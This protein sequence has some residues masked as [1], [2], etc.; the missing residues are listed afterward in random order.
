MKYVSVLFVACLAATVSGII[1]T[2]RAEGHIPKTEVDLEFLVTFEDK[3][4]AK[5]LDGAQKQAEKLVKALK[6]FAGE[7]GV[8]GSEADIEAVVGADGKVT[9]YKASIEVELDLKDQKDIAKA[10]D[11]G[12]KFGQLQDVEYEVDEVPI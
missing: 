4:P 12:S 3:A 2:G 6:G 5:A 11:A 1:V 7:D 8:A 10:I 9:G